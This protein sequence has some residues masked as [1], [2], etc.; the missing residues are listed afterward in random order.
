MSRRY[1]AGFIFPGYDPL[2][3]PDA[4]TIGTATAGNEQISITFTAPADTGG[5]AITAYNAVAITGGATVATGT[6]TAS[7]I[8]VTGLINGTAYTARVWAL[9]IYGPS[10]LSAASGSVTPAL[11]RG[12]FGGG[13]NG[14]TTTNV[15][16]YVD[17]T[18]AGNTTDFGDLS[19]GRYLTCA[20][21]SSTRGVF[22]YGRTTGSGDSG[23]NTIDYVTIAS[24]GNALDFGDSVLP[25][26]ANP[27]NMESSACSSSTRGIIFGGEHNGSAQNV[28]AYIT[29][30]S[31]G[32]TQDF[33]DAL[34]VF[35]QSSAFSSPTRG[36]A[37]GDG[38]ST[39]VIQY[40]TIASTG[41]A[42]DFGDLIG[43]TIYNNTMSCSS[44]TRGVIAGS[45]VLTGVPSFVATNVIQY[46]TIASTGNGTDFGDLTV[47]RGNGAGASSSTRGLFG[48]GLTESTFRNIIDFVVIA[49]TGNA[50]DFGDLAA[51]VFGL[52]GCSSAHGGLQ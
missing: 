47:A 21:S 3:V 43:A 17:I 44:S 14:S 41:N 45:K 15:I 29:I 12:L 33:G 42:T 8:T 35:A 16:G 40:V 1:Q 19:S 46:V 4:P 27:I 36:V 20:C 13:F 38:S 39:N 48:G 30:A 24:T 10:P 34:S 22:F 9:N 51:S 26:S 28:I 31:T 11:A 2:E 18:S 49:S 5:G 50:T 32:N 7:P 23:V 52:G 37:A 6:N 25:T